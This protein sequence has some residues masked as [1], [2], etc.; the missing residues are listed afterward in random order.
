MR[1]IKNMTQGM[2]LQK[3]YSKKTGACQHVCEQKKVVRKEN[4]D[5]YFSTL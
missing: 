4:I 1:Q 5:R 3:K 2:N